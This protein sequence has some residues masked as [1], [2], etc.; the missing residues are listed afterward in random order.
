M[1]EVGGLFLLLVQSREIRGKGCLHSSSSSSSS[2]STSTTTT[3]STTISEI[4]GKGCL[5]GN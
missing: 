4:R 1:S 3:T 5:R 2:T